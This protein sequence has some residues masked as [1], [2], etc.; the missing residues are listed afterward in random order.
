MPDLDAIKA[1]AEFQKEQAKY[2]RSHYAE[3]QHKLIST[4]GLI[5]NDPP[6]T[7]V[8]DISALSRIREEVDSL[9]RKLIEAEKR[10]DTKTGQMNLLMDSYNEVW[11]AKQAEE[12]TLYCHECER[13][14]PAGS[15][16]VIV[17]DIHDED[18]GNVWMC[19]GCY[20]DMM[21]EAEADADAERDLID[22]SDDDW[23]LG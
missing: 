1:E 4:F 21:A 10:I 20:S 15:D 8:D 12:E 22:H 23:L 9:R 17:L 16:G 19:Q 5:F 7:Y 11:R 6:M 18:G 2:W 13:D 14:F 3:L